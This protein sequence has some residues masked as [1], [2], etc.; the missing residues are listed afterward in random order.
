[1]T[2]TKRLLKIIDNSGLKRVYIAEK[3]GIDRFSL[4]KKIRNET[5][6]KASEIKN[7]CKILDITDDKTISEIFFS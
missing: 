4:Y 1:M 5:E 3:L 2:D 7:L 6:F